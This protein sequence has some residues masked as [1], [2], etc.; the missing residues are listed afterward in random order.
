MYMHY[1]YDK[2]N[3]D[4]AS[5]KYYT[6]K[7]TIY[8][9]NRDNYIAMGI[10]DKGLCSCKESYSKNKEV[11]CIYSCNRW[12]LSPDIELEVTKIKNRKIEEHNKEQE[13]NQRKLER[14]QA[15][16]RRLQKENGNT[17]NNNSKTEENSV[18]G[19]IIGLIMFIVFLV[20]L[21][22]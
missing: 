19:G 5:C 11:S 6:G 22:T 8:D 1:Y 10:D 9:R 13:I 3:K 14:E 2:N 7:R 20:I 18:I 4:C 17:N 16:T 15:N 12:S 21:F